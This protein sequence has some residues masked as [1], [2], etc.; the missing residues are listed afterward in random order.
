MKL[1]T[2]FENPSVTLF[3]DPTTTILT[4]KMHTGS[5]L[6]FCKII[7]KA[8]CDDKQILANFHRSQ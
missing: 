8:A 3:K 4:L 7:P 6:R 1:Y 5:R 2:R